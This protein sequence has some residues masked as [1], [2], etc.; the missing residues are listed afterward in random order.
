MSSVYV[1]HSLCLHQCLRAM[2]TSLVD[3]EA[4]GLGVRILR[5][6]RRRAG[7]GPVNF[8]RLPRL[9][10]HCRQNPSRA[11]LRM[12]Q[13]AKGRDAAEAAAADGEAASGAL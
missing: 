7:R 9:Q 10:V 2:T 1:V 3:G 6:V 4:A 8:Q 5:V 12:K 11:E 13:V